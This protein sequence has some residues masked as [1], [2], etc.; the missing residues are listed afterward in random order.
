MKI[1]A[2]EAARGGLV[3]RIRCECG[4]DLRERAGAW[5]VEC[6]CGRTATVAALRSAW[7]GD[8]VPDWA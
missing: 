4:R 7:R 8:D 6:P 3:L 5:R 1:V 2:E